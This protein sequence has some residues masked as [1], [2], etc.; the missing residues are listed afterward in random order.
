M[1]AIDSMI[2]SHKMNKVIFR[3]ETVSVTGQKDN[4][5]GLRTGETSVDRKIWIGIKDRIHNTRNNSAEVKKVD[6]ETEEILKVPDSLADK[7]A[8]AVRK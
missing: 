2:V 4:M 7:I 8:L 1:I 6:S 3:A 5:G